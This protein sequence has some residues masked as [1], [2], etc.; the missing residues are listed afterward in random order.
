MRTLGWLEHDT[1]GFADSTASL[2]ASAMAQSVAERVYVDRACH[3]ESLC[4][5]TVMRL[6]ELLGSTGNQNYSIVR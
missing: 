2:I 5:V 4:I 1:E 6:Q 3:A